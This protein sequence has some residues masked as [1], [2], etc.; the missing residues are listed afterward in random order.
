M[1]NLRVALAQI[2]LTVGDIDGNTR[3][4]L[5]NIDYA[6]ESKANV[7]AFP[8]LT[9]PGYPPEDLL[10]KPSFI[11]DNRIAL[12][13]VV[14]AAKDITVVTGFIESN[15]NEVYNS[16]A[17]A[18]DSR[19]IGTY[20]KH[21]LPNYGVFDEDRYFS[22][23][24]NNFV[25]VV[26]GVGVGVNICEDIWYPLGPV[27]S[28]RQAGAE[29]I[30]N[31]N[32]SPYQKGKIDYREQMLGSRSSD[33][34]LFIAYV[35]MVG[36]QDELIF[37]GGSMVVDPEG[38]IISRA[39]QF[40]EKMLTVD[41]D[42]DGVFNKRLKEPRLRKQE[43]LD[44]VRTEEAKR[45]WISGYHPVE[46]SDDFTGI[47]EEKLDSL[48]EIYSALVLGIRDY[49]NKNG[50]S[51]VVIGISGG[52]DSALTACLA[53]DALGSSNVV[54][55]SMPSRFSSEGSITDCQELSKLLGIRIIELPLELVHS[56]FEETLEEY[57]DLE[58]IGVAEQNIQPRI[59]GTLIMALS[60]KYGWL[61]LQTGNKSEIAMGYTTLYGDMSGGFAVLKDVSKTL[62]Y[63]LANWRNSLSD[64]GG[65]FLSEL[66]SIHSMV[67]P[68]SIISKPPSAELRFDHK[69]EDDLPPYE[70]LDAVLEAYVEE[71]L[72]K[73]EIENLGITD[74]ET[75]K[76]IIESVDRNEYKRRQSPIGIKITSRAFGR[77][78]RMPI[79]NAYREINNL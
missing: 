70:I 17:I 43:L 38:N 63:Q 77:D 22:V 46:K 26:N 42:A 64:R 11:R 10:L 20:Q 40:S 32:G 5:E 79:T 78:R 39:P 48:S 29:V 12:G 65:I 9:I 53:V 2:D 71:D 21:F 54:G 68:Q 74:S 56:S 55:V 45:V 4:I 33:N 14:Q 76:K 72:V 15:N 16:A 60:N 8:E 7:I 18:W 1:R 61:V 3:K 49:V 73:E 67:I 27:A 41:I 47:L 44:N 66:I 19:L 23:G 57:L 34:G 62:V 24:K 30:L 58:N 36:G 69:D 28:Q 37:D 59:R 31:I 52:I 51:K 35:N 25:F 6:R 13:K 50:F 75:I